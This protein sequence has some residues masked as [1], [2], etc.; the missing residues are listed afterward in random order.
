MIWELLSLIVCKQNAV[1]LILCRNSDKNGIAKT[2]ENFEERFNKKYNYPYVFLNDK[3]FTNEFKTHL[4]KV[5]KNSIKFGKIDEE[6][7]NMPKDIDKKKA[8]SNWNR[9]MSLGVPYADKESYHNMCRFYAMSFYKHELL[10]DYDYYWRIEPDV[11]FHCD[12]NFDPFD[13]LHKNNKKYGFVISIY[14]FMASIETLML[15]TAKFLIKHHVSFKNNLTFMFDNGKYNGCH[16][17]SNFEIASFDF[18]R[19]Q[20]YNQYVDFLN[21]TGGFYYERWG[22][23]PIHSIAA[24]LFLNKDQIHF[25][26]EIGYTHD[27]FTH[28]PQNGLNCDCEINRS[29]DFTPYSCLPKFLNEISSLHNIQK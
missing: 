23:A 2:I 8:K 25:F 12:I 11:K 13:Y 26:N 10:L 4:K 18:F 6:T 5:T 24:A 1:I 28:C 7:W 14:E 16:F 22:D 21:N 9:M 29:V 20:I 3:E 19:S 27:I 17:W 15:W